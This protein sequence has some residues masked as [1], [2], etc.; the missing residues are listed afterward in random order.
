MNFKPASDMTPACQVGLTVQLTLDGPIGP[1]GM[2][3]FHAK[4]QVTVGRDFYV[5][6]E[7]FI[8]HALFLI[9]FSNFHYIPNMTHWS[10]SIEE[11]ASYFDAKG[12]SLLTFCSYGILQ[13]MIIVHIPYY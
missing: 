5:N 8:F 2:V 12:W 10:V 1:I 7:S 9:L 4:L 11:S 13:S 3:P 6:E